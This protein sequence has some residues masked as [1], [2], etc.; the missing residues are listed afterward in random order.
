MIFV[1]IAHCCGARCVCIIACEVHTVSRLAANVER[2]HDE[3]WMRLHRV[4]CAV[5]VSRARGRVAQRRRAFA[6]DS[7]RSTCSERVNL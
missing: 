3:V 6:G 5:E 1:A 4:A 2:L 7:S